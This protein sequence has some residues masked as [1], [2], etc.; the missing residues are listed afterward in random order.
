M[1]TSSR[2]AKPT[3]CESSAKRPSPDAGIQLGWQGKGAQEKGVDKKTGK[4]L[5][6]VDPKYFRP[7]EVDLLIGDITK[8][9]SKLGWSPKV[10]FEELVK[11]MMDHDLEAE[12]TGTN[13][14]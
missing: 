6:E 3:P 14:V 8:A 4:V 13:Q 7:T 2:R 11:I 5:I 10:R 12:R 1:T 9:K